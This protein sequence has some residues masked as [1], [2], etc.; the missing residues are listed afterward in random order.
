[1]AIMTSRE[2]I[3]APGMGLDFYDFEKMHEALSQTVRAAH[4]RN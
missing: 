4:E 1:M 2:N 3:D